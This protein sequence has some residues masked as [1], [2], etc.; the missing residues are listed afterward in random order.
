M[1]LTGC[2]TTTNRYQS[3]SF[4]AG[5]EVEVNYALDVETRKYITGEFVSINDQWVTISKPA[6]PGSNDQREKQYSINLDRVYMIQATQ[7]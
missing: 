5:Q 3:L 6:A 2:E 4:S 7:E 1:I